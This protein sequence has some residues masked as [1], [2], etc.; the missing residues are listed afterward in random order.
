M[1]EFTFSLE[2]VLE[3]KIK[4]ENEIKIKIKKLIVEKDELEDSLVKL[5]D[6]YMQYK[7]ISLYKTSFLQKV[8]MNYLETIY[9]SI[10]N[11]NIKMKNVII[12]I[13]NLERERLEYNRERKMLEKL[14]DKKSEE[15]KVIMNK[16]E[17]DLLDECANNL[18]IK[19]LKI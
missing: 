9:K 7:D 3:L 19:N 6:Q 13:D 14:K 1:T 15:Y 17:Q 16:K 18:Y 5:N 10:E 4:E 8:A 11:I 2:K 12:E